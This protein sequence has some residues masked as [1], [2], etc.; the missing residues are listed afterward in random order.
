MFKNLFGKNHKT[1]SQQQ[2]NEIIENLYTLD[3][4]LNYIKG[5]I[6]CNSSLE[7][8]VSAFECACKMKINDD[9]ALFETGTFNFTG[10]NLFYFSLVKQFEGE[11]DEYVQIHIDVIY[12]PTDENSKFSNAVWF[13]EPNDILSQI[14]DSKAFQYLKDKKISKLEI[15]ADET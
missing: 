3:G 1:K 6:N 13:D 12:E 10:E 8:I 4:V 9:C 14:T 5:A 15:Y 11:D 2:L 7:E